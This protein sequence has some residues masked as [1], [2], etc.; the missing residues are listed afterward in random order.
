MDKSPM[1]KA[2][3]KTKIIGMIEYDKGKLKEKYLREDLVALLKI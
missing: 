3:V 2:K 1:L